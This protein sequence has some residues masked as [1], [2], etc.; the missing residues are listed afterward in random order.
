MAIP[1]HTPSVDQGCVVLIVPFGAA[2][3]RRLIVP[4]EVAVWLRDE[5][6]A[7]VGAPATAQPQ[8]PRRPVRLHRGQWRA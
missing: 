3:S 2:R 5:L 6:C 8:R 1:K 4:H 7:A